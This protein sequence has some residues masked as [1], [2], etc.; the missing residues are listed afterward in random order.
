MTLV[1]FADRA[2][3]RSRRLHCP[4]IAGLDPRPGLLSTAEE[5]R[6][7]RSPRRLASAFRK[8]GERVLD[9]LVGVVPAVKIQIAFYEAL[10]VP[11]IGAYVAAVRAARERGFIVVGDI[12]RG[13]IGST[14]EAYA[15]GHF[16][17]VAQEAEADVDAVTLSPY[18]GRDSI[19]P[20]LSYC[21][22]AGKGAFALVRTSNATAVEIQDLLAGGRP[23]YR[24]VAAL[25][26]SWGAELRGGL[27]YSSVGAVVGATY[28]RE[29]LE[30][31]AAHPNLLILVPGYGA[32]GGTAADVVAALDAHGSGLLV[33]SSRGILKAYRTAAD[34]GASPMQGIRDAASVM[35]DEIWAA[36]AGRGDGGGEGVHTCS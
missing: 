6:A 18:L 36:F 17:P 7:G 10:G 2:V 1:S 4:V 33:A 8:F 3:E 12:K 35:R 16:G 26:D 20:F 13:D 25:V 9:G 11:G 21:R 22:D 27:G 31:R 15:E 28:P 32:Q 29:L 30:I 23:I 34:R 19:E 5:S 24:H 14:A